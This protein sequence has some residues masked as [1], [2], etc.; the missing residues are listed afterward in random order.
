MT[1]GIDIASYQ[2]AL[3]VSDAVAAGAEF[4]GAKSVASYLP[5][6]TVAAAYHSNID[7]IIAA[8]LGHAKFH[9]AVPNRLN[10]PEV[11]AR[12]Q[13]DIRYRAM[14][15]DAYLLDNEPLDSYGV[16]WRDD[17]AAA[18][19]ETLHSL[20]IRYDQMWFYCPASLTRANGPW[21]K[22]LAL[23]EKGLKIM[24][25]SYG[26]N[27][28]ILEQGEQ[29]FV[30]D[31][32]FTDPELHQF[33]SSW[34]VPGY[35]GKIDRIYSRLSVAELFSAGPTPAGSDVEPIQ[36]AEV[37]GAHMRFLFTRDQGGGGT[38]W[39]LINT[40]TGQFRQTRDQATA[41][42]W[43]EAWGAAH[44]VSV[45]A[46]LAALEAVQLTTADGV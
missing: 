16:F 2:E 34:T 38:L 31:T 11:T 21:P 22:M 15:T 12:F 5:E 37:E 35:T 46:Y 23:R 10:T 14:P 27:D 1:Y 30:G 33:T 7:D 42:L 32:G 19:F 28:A 40:A 6:L 20:G 25:V 4:A 43:A 9:Y 41:N 26:D 36:A 44:T 24:W 17:P 39:T 3:D 18:Y 13:F 29:P 45:T 8:G